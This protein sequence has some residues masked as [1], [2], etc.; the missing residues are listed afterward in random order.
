[1][2]EV[3]LFTVEDGHAFDW[4][5]RVAVKAGTEKEAYRRLR[6]AGLR[7]K[8]IKVSHG[9]GD[10]AA[11]NFFAESPGILFRRCDNEAGWEA[12]PDGATLN[13]RD[14]PFPEGLGQCPRG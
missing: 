5:A 9:P 1:M 8:Q 10:A 11:Q 14:I 7:K 3:Y 6:D 13:W 4:S 2:D 12:I